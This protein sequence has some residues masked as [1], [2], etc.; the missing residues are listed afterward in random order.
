MLFFKLIYL[1]NGYVENGGDLFGASAVAE[2][3]VDDMGKTLFSALC[4]TLFSALRNTLCKA[5]CKTVFEES[6]T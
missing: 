6:L 3:S 1:F 4:K 5:L 2:H